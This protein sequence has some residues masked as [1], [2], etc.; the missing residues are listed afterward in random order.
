MKNSYSSTSDEGTTD[1]HSVDS[2]VATTSE[3]QLGIYLS[4]SLVPSYTKDRNL[5]PE[6]LINID[7][8]T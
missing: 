4:L 1:E 6:G 7:V 3:D 5:S 8:A 2:R